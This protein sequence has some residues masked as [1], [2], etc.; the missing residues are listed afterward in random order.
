METSESPG[1]EAQQWKK[2]ITRCSKLRLS[3]SSIST[4]FCQLHDKSPIPGHDLATLILT[5][6]SGSSADS[7]RCSYLEE[8][9]RL[10]LADTADILST[11]L[12]HSPYATQ[13]TNSSN[14]ESKVSPP[15]VNS[16]CQE[17]VLGLITRSYVSNGCPHS[18]REARAILRALTGWLEG[19]SY[20]ET[21][22]QVHAGGMHTTDAGTSA[23]YEALGLLTLAI[24]GNDHIKKAELS[25]ASAAQTRTRLAG[26]VSHFAGILG[27]SAAT[28]VGTQA[29]QRLQILSRTPPLV[30]GDGKPGLL[31]EFSAGEI[32]SAVQDLPVVNSRAGLY[33]YLNAALCARPLTDDLAIVNYLHARYAGDT[34]SMVQDL[35]VASFDILANAL[36]RHE[37]AHTITSLRSFIANK[38]PLLLLSI[39][40]PLTAE[41]WIQLAFGRID[42]HPFPPLSQAGTGIN[43]TLAA[44][45]QDFLQACLLHG[46]VTENAITGVLGQL[47]QANPPRGGR[48]VKE[49]LV[50]QC[51][52]NVQR[53]EELVRELENMQGNAGAVSGAIVDVS[54]E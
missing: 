48:Y 28:P 34:Q 3:G 24:L 54:C 11:L 41:Y 20:F 17:S 4:P 45:R 30:G 16:S 40:G 25:R 50:Q 18:H 15:T 6:A 14:T 26:A 9:L 39:A 46:L 51:T 22:L 21:M 36:H 38:L 37:S 29:A 31:P 19:C 43:E 33:V 1:L 52:A 13:K 8:I 10:R 7:L 53:A 27:Q 42:V 47:A 35:I 2:L 23:V 44:S 32:S 12:A 49:A 5:A